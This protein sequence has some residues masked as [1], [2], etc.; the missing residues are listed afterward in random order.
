MKTHLTHMSTPFTQTILRNFDAVAH[1]SHTYFVGF[2][3]N[4]RVALSLHDTQHILRTNDI[5]FFGPYETYSFTELETGSYMLVIE[6]SVDFIKN[7]CDY[8]NAIHFHECQLR[9]NI[10]NSIYYDVC[11]ELAVLIYHTINIQNNSSLHMISAISKIICLLMD[12]YGEIKENTQPSTDYA[13][14]RIIHTLEYINDHYANKITLKD[15]ASHVGIHPQYFS[16]FFKKEFRINFVDYLNTFRISKSIAY[17]LDGQYSITE[18]AEKCGFSDHKAFG[19]AFK[20]IYSCTPSQ[21]RKKYIE[22]FENRTIEPRINQSNPFDPDQYFKFFQPFWMSPTVPSQPLQNSKQQSVSL[23]TDLT[24]HQKPFVINEQMKINNV[25]RAFSCLQNHIQEHIRMA[26]R[27]LQFNY[28]RVRDIF[29]DD[30]YVYYEDGDRNVRYN[31]SF[32]DRVMDFFMSIQVIPMIEIG[33][34]P[35][36]LASKNQLSGWQY[37]PNVSH[38]K[39]LARWSALVSAFIEHCIHRYGLDQVRQWYFDFWT[40]PNLKIKDGYW[41]ESQEDFFRF[42]RATWLAIKNVDDK[43]IVGTPTFSM[44]S[45]I[46]WY[47]AYFGYCQKHQIEP[48]FISVHTYCCPDELNVHSGQFPQ[49]HQRS[50]IFTVNYDKDLPMKEILQ[51]KEL[52]RKWNLEHLPIISTSWNLSFFPQDYTRDTCFMGPYIIYTFLHTLDIC[53]G[54]CYWT[55][56]GTDDELYP[57]EQMFSGNPGMIDLLGLK[58]PSYYAIQMY[59]SLDKHIV[60]YD[61]YH[62]LTKSADGFHLLIYNF[63]FYDPVYLGALQTAPSYTER[64]KHFATSGEII[65]HHAI[66]TQPGTYNI[67]RTEL[68][69]E[70]GST[71]NTWQR[72]GS[73]TTME[74]DMVEYIQQTSLPRPTFSTVHVTDQL[75]LD[76][77]I[78]EYGVVLYEI[79]RQTRREH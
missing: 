1:W 79:T 35:S 34:M 47:D 46:D 3:L 30:L 22:D 7:H 55:L 71:Y 37:H 53:K 66:K 58:R 32:I 36:A 21:F 57:N 76:T 44:P 61:D 60:E 68:S 43:I 27:E 73:P 29:S 41:Y 48:N 31:W 59:R 40:S 70:Y 14:E 11:K 26:K 67:R 28:V 65:Y 39:S 78:P 23:Y 50:E 52:C 77:I 45:G 56:H 69:Q 63:C 49:P 16:T 9:Y 33:F 19:L 64:N 38:P 20:K 51:I 62:V 13:K 18:I 75:I 25:G 8:T 42:Y 5:C 12:N 6:I 17:L 72:I 24:T 2:L 10:E 54:L 4:G 15:I 74:P